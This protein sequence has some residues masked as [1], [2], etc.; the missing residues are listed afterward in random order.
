MLVNNIEKDYSLYNI[1]D[2][3]HIILKKYLTKNNNIDILEGHAGIIMV[4]VSLFEQFGNPKFLD[5]ALISVNYL[6]KTKYTDNNKT[7][8]ID[9]TTNNSYSG[10]AHGT[11]GIIAA[12][13]KFNKY[14]NNLDIEETI[15]KSLNFES[16]LF[17]KKTNNWFSSKEKDKNISMAWCHGAPGILLS[18]SILIQNGID[19]PTIQNEI[20]VALDTVLQFGFGRNRSLCH[21]DMGNL[22]IIQGYKHLNDVKYTIKKVENFLYDYFS[23]HNLNKGT[24]RGVESI[25]LMIG[26]SGIGYGFL[27]IFDDSV[28]NILALETPK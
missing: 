25:G 19:N 4:M 9:P 16:S 12:L 20:K 27:K 22:S 13:S 3:L 8:W 18:R 14:R 6:I 5:T 1:I 7:Y 23:N 15:M 28:P 21:G 2:R 24:S 17:N 26:L 10:F 11:S